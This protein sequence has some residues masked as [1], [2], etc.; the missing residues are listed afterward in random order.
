MLT[1]QQPENN[2][3]RVTIQALAAILGGTQSLHTNSMDEALALPSEKSALIALRTQQILEHESGV[4][5]TVDPLAGSYYIES[6][7]AEII[8]EVQRYIE[9]IDRL[10]G[11]MKAVE[12]GY[13]QREIQ[14]AAYTYQKE[15]ESKRRITVGVNE[16]RSELESPQK[17]LKV[18]PR[19]ERQQIESLKR[20]K[21]N[22]GDISGCLA[23][24]RDAACDDLNIMPVVVECVERMASVGEICDVLREVW[25]EHKEN[26]TI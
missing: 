3:V 6:L 18:D 11:A 14:K 4:S 22:R 9:Q 2:I 8:G 25:G 16:Y 24:L 10:G 19:L 21:A 13:F 1:A 20:L 23:R 15:I 12:T 26:V 7:T 5:S 17:T